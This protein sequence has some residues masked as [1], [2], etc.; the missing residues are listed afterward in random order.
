[1]CCAIPRSVS[2]D[3][4]IDERSAL[5]LLTNAVALSLAFLRCFPTDSHYSTCNFA[6]ASMCRTV[7]SAE[8]GMSPFGRLRRARWPLKASVVSQLGRPA[9]S[10]DGPLFG[11][12]QIGSSVHQ[13]MLN[14]R[15]RPAATSCLFALR[16]V[17]VFCPDETPEG[18][19]NVDRHSDLQAV[20]RSLQRFDNPLH[21]V[22]LG[23]RSKL[24][25]R[26]VFDHAPAHLPLWAAVFS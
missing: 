6:V 12:R 26:H 10:R 23:L 9:P 17:P 5:A 13:F 4:E 21:V 20:R 18:P 8:G 22:V 14:I 11:R 16:S 24:A 19:I 7:P 3:R 15:R 1:M 25:D 2:R